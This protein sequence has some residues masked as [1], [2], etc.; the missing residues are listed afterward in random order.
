MIENGPACNRVFNEA[1]CFITKDDLFLS[2]HTC[3]PQ[4]G[5][6]CFVFFFL[7]FKYLWLKDLLCEEVAP[8]EQ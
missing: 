4:K 8:L 2:P 7:M 3:A 1:S 5:F 6:F